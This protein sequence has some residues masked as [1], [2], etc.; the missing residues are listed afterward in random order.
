LTSI[1]DETSPAVV[2]TAAAPVDIGAE[3]VLD[4]PIRPTPRATN[5]AM[6]IVRI[7]FPSTNGKVPAETLSVLLF[8]EYCGCGRSFG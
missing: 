7:V 2:A 8:D 6:K 3:N 4:V 1:T 5:I